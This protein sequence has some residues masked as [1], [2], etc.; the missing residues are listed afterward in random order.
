M[1]AASAASYKVSLRSLGSW[2]TTRLVKALGG[3]GHANAS[4]CLLP[5]QE[6]EAWRAA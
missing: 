2:D 4:S 6:F 5:R 1:G 3:G